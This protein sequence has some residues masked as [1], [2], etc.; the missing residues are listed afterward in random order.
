MYLESNFKVAGYAASDKA[1]TK[2]SEKNSSGFES[3]YRGS[4]LLWAGHST[5]SERNLGQQPPKQTQ[6]RAGFPRQLYYNIGISEA[7]FGECVYPD[8]KREDNSR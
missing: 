8:P 2:T 6:N 4:W 5:V 7:N 3:Q 1:K